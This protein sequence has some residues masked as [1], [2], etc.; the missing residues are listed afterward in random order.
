V[1]VGRGDRTVAPTVYDLVYPDGA[2]DAET[3]LCDPHTGRLYVASK[4]WL[5]GTLYAAPARLS[6][7][8]PNRLR[9]I[10]PVL[11]IATDGAFLPGGHRVVIRGYASATVYDWPS[12]R[13]V[14]TFALPAQPQ[15]EGIA[16][17]ADGTG[18]LSSEGTHS[19]VLEI[20][21]PAA[22]AGAGGTGTTRDSTGTTRDSTERSWWPWAV[23][24]LV[25]LG[26]IGVLLRSLRPR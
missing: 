23:G 3:L 19:K 10:A 4:E 21:L 5:G 15:G 12:M 20:T 16:V 2:H 6:P 1:P 24:G 22:G 8:R 9:A 7:D 13:R 17:A 11:P 14:T 18:Y 25:G 26:A